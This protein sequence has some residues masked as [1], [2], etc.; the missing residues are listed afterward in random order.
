MSATDYSSGAPGDRTRTRG[1][2]NRCSAIEQVHPLLDTEVPALLR[3]R[4]S[5][6]LTQC[7]DTNVSFTSSP[8]WSGRQVTI[9]LTEPATE[10]GSGPFG[11]PRWCPAEELNLELR[12]QRRDDVSPTGRGA[13]GGFDP[14]RDKYFTWPSSPWWGSRPRCAGPAAETHIARVPARQAAGRWRCTHRPGRAR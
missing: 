11:S 8:E 5:N 1:V 3:R 6:P 12:D 9:L 10:L 4:D 2:R 13:P 7:R 14:S